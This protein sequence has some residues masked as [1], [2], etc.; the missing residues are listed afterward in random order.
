MYGNHVLMLSRA[1]YFYQDEDV[2]SDYTFDYLEETGS[3]AVCRSMVT[4]YQEREFRKE[5]SEVFKLEL[6]FQIQGKS[7]LK[8]KINFEN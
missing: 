8:C 6:R 2:P 5:L 4:H 7:V 1:V 3:Y